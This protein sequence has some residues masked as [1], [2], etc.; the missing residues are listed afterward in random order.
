[1]RG[2]P[3]ERRTRAV[4]E[5]AAMLRIVPLLDRRPAELSG[6][7]RQRVAM[8]RAMV[9]R[10]RVFLFDEPLSNIDA[11][12]RSDIRLEIAQLVRRLGATALYVTH[13][14]VE[15]MTL[16]DRIAVLR[17][18]RLLQLGTPREVYER[19]ATSFVGAFLGSPRM[20]LLPAQVGADVIVTGPF[21]LPRPGG[22]LPT[23]LEVG[24]RPEHITLGASGEP[25]EVLA[26]EPLGAETHVVVRVGG[27]DIRARARGFDAHH[28]GDRVG[29]S[30]DASHAM[31]FDADGDG[32]LLG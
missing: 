32:E 2:I 26:V 22:V 30:V 29:V 1:M 14:H 6:G 20:N 9:R 16:G 24:V 17:A 25:G 7:E 11:S 4:D 8:G 12:L 13:D 19:P 27:L 10:P 23:R 5:V 18:G 28:R 15:A 21:R 3:R 31:L